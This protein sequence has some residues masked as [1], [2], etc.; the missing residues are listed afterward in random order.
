MDKQS[1]SDKSTSV[2]TGRKQVWTN[3]SSE[4]FRPFGRL[5]RSF[6]DDFFDCLDGPVV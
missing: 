2:K 4:F 1:E 3:K 5:V 6:Y